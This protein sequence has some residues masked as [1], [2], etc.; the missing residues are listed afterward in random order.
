MS[1]NDDSHSV[2]A[3]SDT[4][5]APSELSAEASFRL[6]DLFRVLAEMSDQQGAILNHLS[7]V[8]RL[9]TCAYMLNSFPVNQ[10]HGTTGTLQPALPITERASGE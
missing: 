3:S 2:A 6:G 7:N 1:L 10:Q 5:S 9:L 4:G 8:Y